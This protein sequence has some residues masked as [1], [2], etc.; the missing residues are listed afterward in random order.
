[1]QHKSRTKG[2]PT[3][4]SKPE[5]KINSRKK[6]VTRSPP[7]QRLNRMLCA[8]H[9]NKNCQDKNK[10]DQSIFS[11][12]EPNLCNDYISKEHGS[13]NRFGVNFHQHCVLG[14]VLLDIDPLDDVDSWKEVVLPTKKT[15]NLGPHKLKP[16]KTT[17]KTTN[18]KKIRQKNRKSRGVTI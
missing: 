10:I 3:D 1:M 13:N 16:I 8:I 9:R 17:K 5:L 6:G 15:R 14:H 11:Y 2:T 12:D 7:P 4:N 18:N